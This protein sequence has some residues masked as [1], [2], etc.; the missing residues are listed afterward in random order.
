MV[1]GC[2]GN[3]SVVERKEK[4]RYLYSVGDSYDIVFYIYGSIV[5]W[6]I[7]VYFLFLYILCF[8]FIFWF[9]IKFVGVFDFLNRLFILKIVWI[10]GIWKY[11]FFINVFCYEDVVKLNLSY[12]S[13]GKV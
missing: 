10:G 1:G 13:I 5:D 3:L 4:R 6:C 12:F 2:Y 9:F 7:E 11:N 8:F